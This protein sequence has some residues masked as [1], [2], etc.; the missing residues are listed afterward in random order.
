M[1]T[2]PPWG[3]GSLKSLEVETAGSSL[4]CCELSTALAAGVWAWS[5]GS[6]LT[7]PGC[8]PIS[9]LPHCPPCL[10]TPSWGPS[11][12][13]GVDLGMVPQWYLVSLP[14]F[15]LLGLSS[16]REALVTGPGAEVWVWARGRNRQVHQV[17]FCEGTI[18]IC[19]LGHLY[20]LAVNWLLNSPAR[21]PRGSCRC[22]I[23]GVEGWIRWGN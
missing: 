6:V 1:W 12:A 8:M 2:P 20:K 14:S 9:D 13:T 3:L 17:S 23:T 18:A 19:P 10:P 16:W 15:G 21:A 11:R 7:Q 5:W 22:E 4:P